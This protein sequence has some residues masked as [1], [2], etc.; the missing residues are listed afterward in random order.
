MK[1]DTNIKIGKWEI[2]ALTMNVICTQIF[3]NLPRI[4][5]ESSGTAA[6]IQT[7]YVSAIAF[8]LF[9]IIS[10]LYLKHKEMDLID[11][12]E[13]IGGS[14]GRIIVGM[15]FTGY[16]FFTTII[17]LREFAENLK[18][19]S[20][21]ESPISFVYVFFLACLIAGAI[22][23]INAVARLNGFFV[24]IIAS[25]FLIILFLV[26][27]YYNFNNLL[28][29][30]GDGFNSIFITG[31]SRVS[32]YTG[33]LILFFLKPF[34][35]DYRDFNKVGYIT[36]GFAT[37]FLTLSSFVY[38][39]VFQYPITNEGFLPIYLMANLVKFGR[40]FERIEAIF[41]FIWAMA[42]FLYLSTLFTFVCYLFK[43]TFKL[44]NYKPLIAAITILVFNVSLLPP[45]LVT[46]VEIETI[47]IRNLGWIIGF[48]F[49]L[50][51]LFIAMFFKK[52]K[53]KVGKKFA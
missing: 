31:A 17:F 7:L 5:I 14:I 15:I 52:K 34:L 1:V 20:L 19:I 10:K 42:A 6:W 12:A 16:V 32:I 41:V 25:G 11:I 33:V 46:S 9:A 35:K 2:I 30:M 4:M 29:I 44:T 24:P 8:S 21:R 26:F 36:L 43:K 40:F 18:T 3:L 28:P 53:R 48:A 23:G 27:P 13:K 51:I 22:A 37:V 45:N 47:Y 49:P 50:L 39:L 38:L